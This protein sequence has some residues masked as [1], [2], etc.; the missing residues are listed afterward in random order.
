[1]L[2]QS[3]NTNAGLSGNTAVVG[4][5]GDGKLTHHLPAVRVRVERVVRRRHRPVRLG[6]TGS[7]TGSGADVAGQFVVDGQVESATGSGQTLTGK[8]GNAN[9]DGLLVR[10]TGSDPTSAAVTVTQGL[11]GKLNSALGKFLDAAGGKL[12]AINDGYTKQFD[13]LNAQI[14]QQNTMMEAK[15]TELTLRFADM[16]AAVSKLKGL[17]ASLTSLIP[18]ASY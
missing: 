3:I 6:F 2:Q 10:A 16:E 12:K 8:S 18:K 9:T 13:D 1:M 7:E 17:G 14:T 11:A 15:K 5:D 4:V